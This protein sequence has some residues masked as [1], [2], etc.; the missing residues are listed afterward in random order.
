MVGV[1]AGKLTASEALAELLVA[2]QTAEAGC[3][4]ALAA[5]LGGVMCAQLRSLGPLPSA[6]ARGASHPLTKALHA[7]ALAQDAVLEAVDALL[8]TT[9]ARC[10]APT[11]TAPTCT[12]QGPLDTASSSAA[13][14]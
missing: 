9:D 12:A 10:A 11:C 2:L 8:R 5:G 6:W 3:R 14:G 1:N 7:T 4:Q 13:A